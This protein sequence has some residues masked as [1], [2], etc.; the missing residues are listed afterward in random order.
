[1]SPFPARMQ[2]PAAPSERRLW[3]EAI[4]G[5][6]V[7]IGL[8]AGLLLAFGSPGSWTPSLVLVVAAVLG[9]RYGVVKGVVGSTIPIGVFVVAEAVRQLLGGDAD[10]GIVGSV[11]IGISAALI[12]AGF[13]AFFGAIR[14]RYRPRRD[15]DEV[16]ARR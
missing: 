10:T 7:A 5:G 3:I 6:L 16:T 11:V 14:S 12:I 13:A 4:V 9:W 15:D 1:M 8:I 2:K